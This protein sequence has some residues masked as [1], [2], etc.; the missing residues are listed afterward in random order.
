LSAPHHTDKAFLREP[1]D[2]S[3][4]TSVEGKR[5]RESE[6]SARLATSHWLP[7]AAEDL[8]LARI[9]VVDDDVAVQSTVRLLLE[10]AGHSVVTAGDGRKGL[11]LC[12]SGDFDLLFLDIFMPGM[13][14]FETMRMVRQHHQMIP[15]IVISG[16]PISPEPDAPDFLTM[17]TK[18]GA[19]S[20]LQKPFK[21]ADLLAAVTGCLEAAGRPSP[22][23]LPSGGVASCR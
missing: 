5:L 6:L 10:R 15:I 21:P 17:A 13:D 14:G 8:S 2:R 19:V 16:R 4:G 23:S 3:P 22:S 1:F 12:Q 7:A 11:S 18:L 20:S 9:L